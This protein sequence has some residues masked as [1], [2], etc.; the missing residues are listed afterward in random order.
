LPDLIQISDKDLQLHEQIGSG[1]FGIVYKATW[2]STHYTVAVKK[3]HLTHLTDDFGR[4]FL[5]EL[6]L[7]HNLRGPHIISFLGAC[8]EPGKYALVMEYM[9]LGSLYKILHVDKLQLTWTERL[10]I[11]LQAAE[12]VNYLHQL[13]VPILHRD[14]KS[15]NFLLERT[16]EGYA[17][18]VCDFGVARTRNETTRLTNLNLTVAITL[19]WTAPEILQLKSHTEKSDIYGLGIVY[20]ELATCKIPYDG[21]TDGVI[22]Q[23]VLAGERLDIP[24]NTPLNFC[25]VIKTCWAHDPGDRPD[26]SKLIQMIEQCIRD[27]GNLLLFLFRF[28]Q[29]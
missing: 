4:V 29:V 1:A 7:L 6:S 19:P 2:L 15:L 13:P 5:Q 18:K 11:A 27:G 3:L 10:S 23:F 9:S 26:G 25:M 28:D 17:L 14:I 8:M 12:G 20:W 16:Y 22:R 24:E 21:H